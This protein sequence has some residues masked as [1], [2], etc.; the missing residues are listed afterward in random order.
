MCMQPP[1]T[2]Y[3]QDVC[4]LTIQTLAQLPLTTAPGHAVQVHDLLRVL[5]YA[6]AWRLSVNHACH[7]L[8]GAPS[9]AKVLGELATQLS[10]LEALDATRNGLLGQLVP[11]GPGTRGRRIAIDLIKLPYHGTVA[12]TD[13]DEIRRGKAKQGTP[14]FFTYATAY[15]ILHGRRYTLAL[16]RV[17][18]T[19]TMNEV[20]ET[21]FKH[22]A[23]LG[24]T[25]SVLLLDR[26]FYRVK[27][28]RALLD[29]QQPF[30]RPA[31]K[32]GKTPKQAGRRANRHL[33]DGPMDMQ[34]LD[35]LY[36]EECQGWP[37]NL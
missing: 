2:F 28:I 32:R 5:A 18:A 34:R 36:L 3:S 37:G 25:C 13:H 7:N 10:D 35:L 26:G 4:N 33:C 16:C 29:R 22:V 15:V 9:G 23:A 31:I 27:V 20:L 14:H 17:R 11:R 19:M 12:N 1:Y 8:N 6:A 21:L 24:I 30:I